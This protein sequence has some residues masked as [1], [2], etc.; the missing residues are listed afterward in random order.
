LC[1]FKIECTERRRR[2]RIVGK[3]GG[4]VRRGGIERRDRRGEEEAEGRYF[5]WNHRVTGHIV[6]Y[7]D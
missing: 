2:D 5:L 7:N 6:P 3:N 1:F 4:E